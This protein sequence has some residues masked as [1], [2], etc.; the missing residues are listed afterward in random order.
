MSAIGRYQSHKTRAIVE[1]AIGP[2]VLA[3][4]VM[5]YA[6]FDQSP[7]LERWSVDMACAENGLWEECF[8][9]VSMSEGTSGAAAG[10]HM[11]LLNYLLSTS[12]SYCR[13]SRVTSLIAVWCNDWHYGQD[14]GRVNALLDLLLDGQGLAEL[15]NMSARMSLPCGSYTMISERISQTI[16]RASRSATFL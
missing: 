6:M 14:P 7:E 5:Q 15:L 2:H 3:D 12:D 11:Q 16:N 4:L 8:G 10:G 1:T 13:Q 9:I